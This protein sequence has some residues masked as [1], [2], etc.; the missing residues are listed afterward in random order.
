MIEIPRESD[1]VRMALDS[2]PPRRQDGRV[3]VVTGAA[4]G[5]GGACV[6]RLAREGA[7]VVASDIDA[8]RGRALED[9]CRARGLDVRFVVAD[10]AVPSS[11]DELLDTAKGAGGDLRLW[12]NCAFRS[13]F[14]PLVEQTLEEFDDT[15]AVC[16]RGYWYGSKLAATHMLGHG[17]GVIVN[18]ASVQSYRG[19]AGFSAYQTVKGGILAL[20]RSMGVELA[21]TVRAVAVA[22]GF[23]PT[24]AHEGIPP[25]VLTAVVDGIPARRGA[26][27]D[28][29][30]AAVAYLA[31]DEADYVTATGLVI[32]GGFLA[33]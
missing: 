17:G 5:I 19:Y 13:T 24:A 6:I 14:R 29:V 18:V 4:G 16:L 11:L 20:T 33:L 28:E 27:V 12:V 3:A 26:S 30:A 15:V 21:P 1:R 31:S 23:V 32:D 7:H 10:S 9:H 2:P 8:D 22:P 25:D